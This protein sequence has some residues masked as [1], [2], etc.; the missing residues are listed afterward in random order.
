MFIMK[1]RVLF[2]IDSLGC[3]GAEKSLVSLLPLLD[4]ERLDIDL[5]IVSRGGV[6]EQYVPKHVRIISLPHP[7]G[8]SKLRSLFSGLCLSFSLAIRRLLPRQRHGSEQF[9]TAMR[10]SMMPLE[11]TYDVAVA[12]HQGLPTYYVA[13][14]VKAARK[15]AVVN[16]DLKQAGYSESFNRPFY[17][18]FDI[19]AADSEILRKMLEAS[20]YVDSS[21]LTAIY[22]IMNS[23]L[24]RRMAAEGGFEDEIPAGALRIVTTGR[25]EAPKN[26][27]LAV[28][29]AKRLRDSGLSFRWYFIGDG[30]QR[31]MIERLIETYGLEEH[32]VL[33]GMQP[34]PYPYMAQCDMYVQTSSFEGYCLALCEA[35]ILHRPV[36]STNFDVVYD[37]IRD[38]ENGLIAEMTPESLAEKILRL[39]CSP[40]LRQR[41][42]DATRRDEDRT[43]ETES[44]KFNE[45]LLS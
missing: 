36:V 1:R 31:K 25:I 35:R 43:A 27:T 28:E 22:D 18:C 39:A 6:F 42:I 33:L 8:I 14:K 16:S 23:T 2:V 19:V 45:M 7:E 41:L 44:A 9:W 17:D 37:K 12:Y 29:T 24:I 26:Y 4:H 34:N 21:K 11:D 15:C 13:E 20:S 30:S 5:L 3:G 38:G 32:V 10:S 40:E